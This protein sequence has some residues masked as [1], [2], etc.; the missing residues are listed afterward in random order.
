[1]SETSF[2]IFGFIPLLGMFKL[3]FS[4]SNM[5]TDVVFDS[6]SFLFGMSEIGRHFLRTKST[7]AD[8]RYP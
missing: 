3:P 8:Q 4:N 5:S 1:M 6:T 2:F 7:V